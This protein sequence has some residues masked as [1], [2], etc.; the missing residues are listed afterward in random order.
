[1]TTVSGQRIR[2]RSRITD[3]KTRREARSLEPFQ[4]VPCQPFFATEEMCHTRDVD[5]KTV[6]A[7][8]VAARAIPSQPERKPSEND[9]ITSHLTR[10]RYQRRKDRACIIQNLTDTHPL[11][12]GR[13]VDGTD[14]DAARSALNKCERLILGH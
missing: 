14:D 8:D 11:H 10:P 13:S 9:G 2:S 7:L 3:A 4:A 5:P 12:P 6:L 1:M